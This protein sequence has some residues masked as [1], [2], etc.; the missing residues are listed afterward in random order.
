MPAFDNDPKAADGCCATCRTK[1]LQAFKII[2]DALLPRVKELE[3]IV[4]HGF[5]GESVSTSQITDISPLKQAWRWY[6]YP[7]RDPNLFVPF[8]KIAVR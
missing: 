4:E 1:A 5:G 8:K 3:T 7:I 6:A 2:E